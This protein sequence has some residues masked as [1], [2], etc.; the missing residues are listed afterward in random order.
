[1]RMALGRLVIHPGPEPCL[2]SRSLKVQVQRDV[3]DGDELN[4]QVT[5]LKMGQGITPV[6]NRRVDPRVRSI[7]LELVGWAAARCPGHRRQDT[8]IKPRDLSTLWAF[9]LL[10]P[11]GD[12]CQSPSDSP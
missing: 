7:Y 11:R 6:F 5:I 10:R 2:D 8:R 1:M 12:E 9:C 4:R 3:G